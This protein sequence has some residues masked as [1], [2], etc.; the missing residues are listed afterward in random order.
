MIQ[1]IIFV[2][3]LILIIGTFITEII[4]GVLLWIRNIRKKLPLNNIILKFKKNTIILGSLFISMLILIAFSHFS[5]STPSIV[6]KNGK[7][8][9]ESIAELRR[10]ELNGKQEWVSIRGENRN[11]P[12][13]LFL[14]GGPG[15]T[16]MAAVRYNLQKLEKNFV[17]VNWDQPG[18]G[19][20]YYAT[21]I[22]NLN[23]NN[24]IQDGYEL[25]KYL[26]ET[27]K[28]DKIYLV[29]ESWGSALGIF[30]A[31]K[32]PKKYYSFIGTGQMIDFS[33]TE[34][35]DYKKA[36]EIA[37]IKNDTNKI[38]KLKS[39][40]YP[41]YYG[42]DVTWKSAEYLNYLSSYMEK[43]PEIYNSRFNTWRDIFSPEYDLIDKINFMRG[44][45]NTFNHVY[46]QLYNINLRK[47]YAKIEIPVYFF[48]GKRDINAPLSLIEDYYNVLDAPHK[49]I[50]WFEHSGHSP[51]IN[52]SDRFIK[53]VN[54]ILIGK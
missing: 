51:W 36:I 44:L 1:I 11:N 47:D 41:P 24:Y 14:A 19:K 53:Q 4:I 22:K 2:I 31:E 3:L 10:V 27:F 33:K 17:V 5:A 18:S 54:K 39:N 35:L 16:Q 23:V 46:P 37:E 9:P 48:I 34:E 6:D 29:G 15:G 7:T 43:D 42:T 32:Y 45:I 13:L 52:E 49:E 20:S 38:S 25:T 30:L 40:G 12:V 28:K 21:N 26:C 8:V 50:V